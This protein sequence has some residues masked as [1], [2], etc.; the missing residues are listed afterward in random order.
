[1]KRL[2]I[3]AVVVLASTT[4]ALCADMAVKSAAVARQACAAAQWGGFY[5]GIN[6]GGALHTAYRRDATGLLPANNTENNSISSWGGTAGGQVGY[7]FASCSTFWGIEVDGAWLGN[8]RFV[9]TLPQVPNEIGG[10]TA[11][12]DG[13]VTL[14]V[15]GGVALDSMLFYVTGGGAALHTRTN[16]AHVHADNTV[17]EQA[18]AN[19]WTWGWVAGIGAEYAFSSNLSFRTEVLYIGTA[20]KDYRTRSFG[21]VSVNRDF[22]QHDA[23]AIARVGLNYRFNTP[24]VAKY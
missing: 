11:R 14:R 13:V 10:V 12:A 24:V 9:R 21:T 19:D 8:D 7:N 17:N 16:Y 18:N 3:G 15:R 22:T 4:S 23:L 20:D 6:G 1:M 5:A 2:L